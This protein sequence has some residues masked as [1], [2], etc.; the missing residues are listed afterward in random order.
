MKQNKTRI[1]NGIAAR[2][3]GKEGMGGGEEF[4]QRMPSRRTRNI[5]RPPTRGM[6]DSRFRA[7]LPIERPP[8]TL[9]TI[10]S[11]EGLDSGRPHYRSGL[12][13]EGLSSASCWI[14]CH[15]FSA[16]K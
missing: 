4:R 6:M 12:L 5:V 9:P 16:A 14:A 15:N 10:E 8:P 1:K 13:R 7:A 3:G 11:Q 2:E